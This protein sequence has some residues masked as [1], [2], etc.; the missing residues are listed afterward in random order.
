MADFDA[1]VVV[2]FV[3]VGMAWPI[4][5]PMLLPTSSPPSSETLLSV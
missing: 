3:S 5:S 2:V 1:D 4:P